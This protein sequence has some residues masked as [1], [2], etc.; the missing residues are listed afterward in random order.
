M[1]LESRMHELRAIL[2]RKVT[3]M[4]KWC[5]REYFRGERM[6]NLHRLSPRQLKIWRHCFKYM[7]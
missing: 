5:T 2:L 1:L 6:Q 4:G 7:H 3:L